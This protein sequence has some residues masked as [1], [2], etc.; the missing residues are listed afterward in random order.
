MFLLL[1]SAIIR[2]TGTQRALSSTK[3]ERVLKVALATLA[4]YLV[5]PIE[6]LQVESTRSYTVSYLQQLIITGLQNVAD[7]QGVFFNWYPPKKLKYGKPRLGESTT[8]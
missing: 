2:I 6:E 5:I 1:P 4:K 8:T 7:I 3:R